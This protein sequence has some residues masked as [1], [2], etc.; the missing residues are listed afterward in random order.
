MNIKGRIIYTSGGKEVNTINI[1]P[2]KSDAL[3]LYKSVKNVATIN[4]ITKVNNNTLLFDECAVTGSCYIKRYSMDVGQDDILFPGRLPSYILNH[5]K[6]F[7]Y[8]ESPDNQ[9]WLYVI[10][11]EDES[12]SSKIIKEPKWR[13]LPNGIRQPVTIPVIQ[14][15]KNEVLFVG[16]EEQLLKYN[17]LNKKLIPT[18]INNCRPILW[19]EKTNQLLCSDWNTNMPFLLDIETLDKTDIQDLE[20]AYGFIYMPTS[21]SLIYGRTRL[22]FFIGEAYDIFHYSFANK[23]EERIIKNVHVAAGVWLD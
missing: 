10:S 12:S 9:N 17:I 16:E 14:I 22:N 21:D 1:S 23:K 11:Y 18:G 6:L 13:M 4:Y 5:N 20:G 3:P 19:K 7:F 2:S 8:G 15:S